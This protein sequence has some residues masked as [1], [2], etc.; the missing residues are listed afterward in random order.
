MFGG[1][2][3]RFVPE[4]LAQEIRAALMGDGEMG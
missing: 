2:I 3:D 1:E 4:G